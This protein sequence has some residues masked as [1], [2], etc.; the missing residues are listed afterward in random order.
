MANKKWSI[1]V[2]AALAL[3]SFCH[4]EG[5]KTREY[6]TI[7][8]FYPRS[9]EKLDAMLDLYFSRAGYKKIPGKIVGLIGPHAGFSFSGQCAANAYKQLQD[10]FQTGQIE[11]VILLGVSHRSSFHGAAVSTFDYNSTPLGKIPVDTFI[12]KKLA[13]EKL[14]KVSNNIMQQEHSIENHLPFLQKAFKKKK[15]KIVPILLS[16]LEEKDFKQ[17]AAIIKKFINEKTLVIASTDFTHYGESFGYTPF[18]KDIKSNLTKLDM[19][20]IKYI[21][22]L[23]FDKYFT[24]IRNTNISMCGFIPVGVLIEIFADKKHTAA[25]MDYY[26][27]GDMNNDYSFSVSYASIIISKGGK[28]PM[29]TSLSL[30]EK[31]K[32]VLLAIARDTIVEYLESGRHLNGIEK[33]Y[34]ISKNLK[35]TTGVFVTLKKNGHLRGCI[36]SLIGKSPLYLGVMDNAINATAKDYRFNPVKKEELKKI[37]IEV[38]VMT[39]LQRI[40]DYKK[41]RLGTDGVIVKKGRYQSVF[42]PQVA[43]ET[44]WNLD[45]FLSN[46]CRKAGLPADSYLPSEAN[47]MEFYIFQAQVFGEKTDH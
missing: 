20:I 1:F 14:F 40:G 37:N 6:L 3:F 43:T 11:R 5:D 28:G 35:E 2:F 7:V 15:F 33:K 36:G 26:K 8:D 46:L 47:G 25:L 23:D 10:P 34:N 4:S 44:G 45:Q 12:T 24:Y 39:P 19:G 38:S 21:V 29:K 22:N 42:L 16:Y 13:K 17:I 31:E 32:K 27:S 9:P 41:I 30:N 18:K